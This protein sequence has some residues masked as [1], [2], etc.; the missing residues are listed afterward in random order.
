M[1]IK[2]EAI[3]RLSDKIIRVEAQVGVS[4]EAAFREAVIMALA[5]RQIVQLTFNEKIYEIQ[6]AG[7]GVAMTLYIQ[8]VTGLR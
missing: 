8:E 1:D 5:E 3:V 6:I 4:K 2:F 7:V